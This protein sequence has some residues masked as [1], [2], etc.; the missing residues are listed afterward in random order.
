MFQRHLSETFPHF[1][2]VETR[3]KVE[4]NQRTA[5]GQTDQ[6][7]GSSCNSFASA[8]MAN[9]TAVVERENG[10]L[11]DHQRCLLYKKVYKNIYY[12][13]KPYKPFT[14]CIYSINYIH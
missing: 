12:I 2:C 1:E 8:S 10:G 14:M 6:N 11:R 4:P 9:L 13:Y 3:E 7:H 5:H